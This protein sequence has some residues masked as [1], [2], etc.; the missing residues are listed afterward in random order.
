MMRM[1]RT[2]KSVKSDDKKVTNENIEYAEDYVQRQV[3]TN[4]SRAYKAKDADEASGKRLG[5]DETS[6]KVRLAGFPSYP[7]RTLQ[8]QPQTMRAVYPQS[9]SNAL[10]TERNNSHCAA[11]QRRIFPSVNK[12]SAP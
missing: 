2:E 9:Q 6:Q 3:P 4:R 1:K 12:T 5:D 7:L 8:F 11:V 10:S